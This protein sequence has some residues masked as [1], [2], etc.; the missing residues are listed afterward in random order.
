MRRPTSQRLNV[1]SSASHDFRRGAHQGAS[2]K[3][4]LDT[5]GIYRGFAMRH[6]VRAHLFD[7]CTRLEVRFGQFVQMTIEVLLDLAFGLR[8]EAKAHPVA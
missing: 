3:R 5:A 8:H 7:D 6:F 1:V 4:Q 2:R